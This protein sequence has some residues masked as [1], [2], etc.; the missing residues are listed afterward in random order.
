MHQLP[1]GCAVDLHGLTAG[2]EEGCH[3]LTS[4]GQEALG[5]SRP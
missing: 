5:K 3:R 2:Q 1:D 4:K